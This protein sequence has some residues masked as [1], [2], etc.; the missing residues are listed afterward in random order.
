MDSKKYLK[1]S[2]IL[3]LAGSIFAG[4]L[5]AVK[6]F[7]STCAFNEP[8]PYFLGYPA[9]Y[10]GFAMFFVMFIV[11]AFAYI[12]KIKNIRTAKINT[13]ISGLGI[14]FAGYFT[15]QEIITFTQAGIPGYTLILPTCTYGLV[16][17]AIIFII[18]IKSVFATK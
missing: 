14:L 3:T 10:Y 7:S 17:Y 2:I 6:L 1:V 11:T 12:K 8:C 13:F 16:F 15:I 4:F 18:S 5:S 9:C